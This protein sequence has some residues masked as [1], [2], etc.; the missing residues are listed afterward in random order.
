MDYETLTDEELAELYEDMKADD[1]I[2]E[3]KS[4]I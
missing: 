2:N 4:F 1:A 3:S